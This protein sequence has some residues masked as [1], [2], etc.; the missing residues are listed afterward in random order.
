MY[1]PLRGSTVRHMEVSKGGPAV[2]VVLV[3]LSV[4]VEDFSTKITHNTF[5]LIGW[6]RKLFILS[7]S[8]PLWHCGC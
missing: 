7:S 2:K 6:F 4:I 8:Y 5:T 3:G 1:T